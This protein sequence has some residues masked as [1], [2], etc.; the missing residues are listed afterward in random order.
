MARN[1]SNLPGKRE[2]RRVYPWKE[3]LNGHPWEIQYGVDFQCG[4]ATMRTAIHQAAKAAGGS[5][6]VRK[7]SDGVL[8][9]EFCSG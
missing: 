4:M 2:S 5:A 6:S 8:A 9:F 7:I 3:W 1:I